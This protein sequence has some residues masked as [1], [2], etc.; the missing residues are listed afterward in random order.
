MLRL[1][2]AALKRIVLTVNKL[3]LGNAEVKTNFVAEIEILIEQ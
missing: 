1:A 2:E 3:I